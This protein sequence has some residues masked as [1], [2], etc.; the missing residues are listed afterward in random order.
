[1][2]VLDFTPNDWAPGLDAR[3]L[4]LYLLEGV[5]GTSIEAE[6]GISAA[7]IRRRLRSLGVDTSWN[8]DRG[9]AL[10]YFE[11]MG[12]EVPSEYQPGLKPARPDF[13]PHHIPIVDPEIPKPDS[14][15]EVSLHWSDIHFPFQDPAAVS[16]LYAVA[17][18]VRPT[19]LVMQGDLLD[20]WQISNHRPPLETKLNP[21][22][23]DL[24]VGID[25]AVEHLGVMST[26]AQPGSDKVY[27]Y[28]NHED[29]F[30]RFLADMQANTKLLSLMRIPKIQE[31]LSLDYLLGIEES[32]WS[33]HHYLENSN[34]LLHDRL[35]CI[36]GYR[37]NLYSA[38]AH[39]QDFGKSVLFGHSHRIQNWTSRDLRG[40]DA[41]WNIGCLCDLN[42]HWRSR[43]NWHQGFAVV[44]WKE[45]A[46]EWYFSV[47]QVRIHEGV[48][49][50]RDKIYRG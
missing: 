35:L 7:S 47:E 16:C 1:M 48:A 36:H 50:F 9:N 5:G 14:Y 26:L 4:E 18:D 19:S 43:P 38:K 46:G 21:N 8:G 24:Q 23:V 6:L 17:E 33:F 44:V 41:A 22:Q 39:L 32:G 45:V 37:S 29:R 42:P 31:A 15:D 10:L 2:N 20:L 3:I 27:L 30:E 28:G 12:S 34:F 40:T 13:S 25:M 49:I 11:I